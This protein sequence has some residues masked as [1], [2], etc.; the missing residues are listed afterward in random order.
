MSSWCRAVARELRH[1]VSVLGFV[2]LAVLLS[3]LLWSKGPDW[4]ARWNQLAYAPR[5]YMILLAP[6][7]VTLGVWLGGRL[8]R[9]DTTELL[10]S[11]RRSTLARASSE[12]MALA[13][14]SYLGLLVGV[15]SAAWSIV[16]VGGYGTWAAVGY[17]AGLFP[18]LLAYDAFGYALGRVLFW[19]AAAP[20]A[21]VLVYAGL[22]FVVW[23]SDRN[24]VPMGGG[25]L[26]GTS[27]EPFYVWAATWSGLGLL[28]ASAALVA[29]A[30]TERRGAASRS[31]VVTAVVGLV[32]LAGTVPQTANALDHL[33]R[34]TRLSADDVA[35]TTDAGPRV[36]V[37][38]E[39][40]HLL[41][42][43][44]RKARTVLANF[45]GIA[46]APTWAGPDGYDAPPGRATRLDVEP[47]NTT[48]WGGPDRRKT[49]G[50]MYVETMSYL[51]PYRYCRTGRFG[52]LPG[53]SG[54][55]FF[56]RSE[57]ARGYADSGDT[58]KEEE[59][60]PGS[61]AARFRASSDAQR[62]N[63][64][65]QVIAAARRCDLEAVVA[66]DSALTRP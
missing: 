7:S 37:H 18:T 11:T 6:I 14:G 58:L 62:R 45:H 33:P 66:A 12:V 55:V 21:G 50:A 19:R 24:A 49:Y 39:D 40:R 25:S 26:G 61:V 64:V 41:D 60:K 59:L 28:A 8:H 53:D 65:G 57:L 1:G 51:S 44:T 36:C 31:W 35:C 54:E 3:V 42:P 29:T 15:A 16:V 10:T 5:D 22:G 52:L 20:V 56:K 47:G 43:M 9:S 38:A 13:I 34:A 46:G 17:L 48:P 30:A 23:N 2:V 4:G 32:I 63:F 27:A